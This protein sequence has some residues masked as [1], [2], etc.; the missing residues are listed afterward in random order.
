MTDFGTVE[1]LLGVN[2]KNAESTLSLAL[3]IEKGLPVAALDRVARFVAPESRNV[4][5]HRFVPKATLERRRKD[6]KPLTAQEGDKV[7]RVAKVATFAI[8]IFKDEDKAREFLTRPHMMLE[9]KTP[10]DVALSTGAGADA[11]MN[12]LGRGAY[13]GAV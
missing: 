13:G 11:V 4:W 5:V 9:N 10:I 8:N 12:I 6:K 3:S 1:T 7:A 2:P